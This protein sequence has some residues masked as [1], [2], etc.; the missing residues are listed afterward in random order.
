MRIFIIIL[1]LT[2]QFLA[3]AQTTTLS[4]LVQVNVNNANISTSGMS[5]CS[6]NARSTISFSA[7]G[8]NNMFY[9]N[10]TGISTNISF[11]GTSVSQTLQQADINNSSVTFNNNTAA[12]TFSQITLENSTFV[13]QGLTLNKGTTYVNATNG[14]TININAPTGVGSISYLTADNNATITIQGTAGTSTR[15]TAL[16]QGEINHNGG[17][18][19]NITKMMPNT[20]ITGAFNHSN[21][22]MI[23][24][25]NR[26]LTGANTNRSEY[27]GVVSSTPLF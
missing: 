22:I 20:L 3:T 8:G 4:E 10:G 11:S 13:A 24:P 6:F 17:S 27:L 14:S 16:Q 1:F 26:T 7:N 25:T 18:A 23:S 19:T 2:C 15:L 21:L 9:T 12:N 5:D